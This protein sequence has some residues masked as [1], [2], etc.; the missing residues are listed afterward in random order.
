M[1][2]PGATIGILGGGQLGRMLALAAHKL[3]LKVHIFCPDPDSPAF[4][5]TSKKTL[6]A[7]DDLTALEKFA[8]SVDL[9]TY[10]FENVPAETAK[11]I[12]NFNTPLA[13]GAKAL[14]TTQDRLVEKSFIKNANVPVVPFANVESQS[15]LQQAVQTIGLPAI[16]KTRRF[17]YD[18]KGQIV[19]RT[20]KDIETAFKELNEQPCILE[21]FVAFDREISVIIARAANGEVA[22]Y[23]PAENVHK[24]AILHTSTVP[25]QISEK[26]A[27]NAIAAAEKIAKAL[28]YV[29]VMGVE[30][31]VTDRD[32]H[33]VVNEIAPRV[34][35]SGHWTEAACLI[36]QFEQHIRAIANWPLGAADR[37]SNV[38]MTNLLGDDVDRIMAALPPHMM[39]H[40]YGK[41]DIRPGR[42]LGH[43]NQIS[44]K[45]S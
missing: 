28:D 38:V 21:G 12:L 22:A 37:H 14:I 4:E 15:D 32:E 9:V 35:N 6:A 5:V 13:P 25:A 39:V 3:G 33:L 43:I 41:Y 45:K 7:Y 34:H 8:N 20:P 42:K 16:L 26:I 29:G 24:N 11:A 27:R 40:H 31:F 10:E 1:L 17:G 18:G 30:F 36:S 44:P 19:L 23:D 2:Q